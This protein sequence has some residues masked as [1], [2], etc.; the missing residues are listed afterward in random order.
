M[1]STSASVEEE[2]EVEVVAAAISVYDSC[3]GGG[4]EWSLVEERWDML[5]LLEV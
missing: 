1:E 3:G 2:V 5:G 4:V